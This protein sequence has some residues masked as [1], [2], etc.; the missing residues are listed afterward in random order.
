MAAPQDNL[1]IMYTSWTTGLPKG[2][3]H[4]HET[5]F[6]AVL[7]LANTSDLRAEDRYLLLLPLFHVGA[8]TPMIG[9]V[10]RGNTL[11]VLA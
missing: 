8:L 9:C 6:W 7:T 10:Y 3:V 4:T 11:V 5:V 2:V 1:F